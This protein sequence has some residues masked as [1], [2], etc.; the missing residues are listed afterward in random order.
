MKRKKFGYELLLKIDDIVEKT[1]VP[2]QDMNQNTRTNEKM[3]G[4]K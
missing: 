2:M 4:S 3:S 1:L